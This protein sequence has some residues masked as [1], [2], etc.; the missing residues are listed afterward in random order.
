MTIASIQTSVDGRERTTKKNEKNKML[1]MKVIEKINLVEQFRL[2][3]PPPSIWM[4][5]GTIIKLM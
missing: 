3:T 4:G 5:G 1:K 2:T